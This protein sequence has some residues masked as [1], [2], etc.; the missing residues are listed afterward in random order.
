[1]LI[2]TC[3]REGQN[4]QQ[5]HEGTE[6]LPLHI[7]ALVWRRATNSTHLQMQIKPEHAP[8][9]R[10]RESKKF[11]WLAVRVGQRGEL[12]N[13][14]KVLNLNLSQKKKANQKPESG[15]V[16][17]RSQEVRRQSMSKNEH[18]IQNS[19]S[20]IDSHSKRLSFVTAKSYPCLASLYCFSI[21]NMFHLKL[22]LPNEWKKMTSKGKSAQR[23]WIND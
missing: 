8:C 22:Q 10:N 16:K 20:Y 9:S 18:E 19:R 15:G 7:K 4:Q 2:H 14:H 13:I 1:M 21:A 23:F 17:V 11:K 5:V 6:Q 3:F 12:N